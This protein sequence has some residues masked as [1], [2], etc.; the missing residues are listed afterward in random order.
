M[1]YLVQI[2]KI[3]IEALLSTFLSYFF[4]NSNVFV[5]YYE[6]VWSGMVSSPGMEHALVTVI[7]GSCPTS[8]LPCVLVANALEQM[9]E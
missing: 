7:E 4:F 9:N 8:L 3:M 5:V 6:T 2:M 1:I